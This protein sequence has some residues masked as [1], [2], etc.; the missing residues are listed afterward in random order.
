[1]RTKI[2]STVKLTWRREVEVN[3]TLAHPVEQ[4]FRYLAD[5]LLWHRFAP[6]VA[7]RRR[8]DHGPIGVGSRWMATDR[9]GPF[10]VHFVDE[11]VVLEPRRR[12]VWVSSAPWNARVEYRCEADGRSTRVRATY[13]GVLG[14]R[15]RVLVGWL[16]GWATRLIL[17]QDFR[18][19]NRLLTHEARESEC[20]RRHHRSLVA[21]GEG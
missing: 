5:P 11:L 6:A 9:I 15:L 19:L 4:V 12:V 21:E 17:A 8:V 13:E 2:A 16:P 3:A 10:R 18:R 7:F 20:W 14:G 1:M